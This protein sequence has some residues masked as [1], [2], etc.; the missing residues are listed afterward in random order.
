MLYK[1]NLQKVKLCCYG[2]SD[3]FDLLKFFTINFAPLDALE[4]AKF[5]Y[6]FEFSI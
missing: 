4:Y 1:C 5:K 6:A 2:N 3:L